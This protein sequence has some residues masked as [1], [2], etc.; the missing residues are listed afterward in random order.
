[1]KQDWNPLE[2]IMVE[3]CCV[4]SMRAHSSSPA[5][6]FLIRS[7]TD[8]LPCS[9]FA[10]R[11]S[12]SADD[13]IDD[14]PFPA[15]SFGEAA[16][17]NSLFPSLR[18]L[19]NDV[20]AL[21]NLAFLRSFQRILAEGRL[22]AEVHRVVAEKKQIVFTGHSFGGAMSVLATIWLLEQ[23]VKFDN[24]SQVIPFCLT[25][26]SPLVGD[27]VFCHSLH[28]EGWSRCF[29]HFVMPLDII[30]RIL[31]TPL[32]SC[33]EELQAILHLACPKYLYFSLDVIGNS[34][35]VAFFY[36]TI[37][38]NALLLSCHR[39][40]LAMGCANP[41]FGSLSAFVKLSPY[42]P[43]GT[44][45]FFTRKGRL[46]NFKNSDA[47]LHLLFYCLQLNPE[48]ELAEVAYGSLKEHLQYDTKVKEYLEVQYFVDVD[49]LERIPLSIND[50][51]S[52]D[53]QVFGVNFEDLDLNVEA[54]LRLRAAGELE[55]QKQ[56]NQENFDAKYCK[57]QEAL[58]CLNDYRV[59]C[60]I[61][62]LG[63]YDTFKLQQ[64]PEDFNA[65]VKRLELAGLWDEILEMLRRYD[66][67]DSFESRAEWVRLGTTYRQIVEPLDIANYYRHSK[68][69][70][71]GPY[72][73]N[74][75][76]KRYRC[77]QR[78]YEQSRRMAAGLSSE[79]CFWAM[80]EDLCTDANNNRP[81]EDVRDKVL[82]L[83]RKVLR[84][85]TNDK[86]GKDVLFHNS[87][88][89]IWWKALPE[90]HK[91]ESCIASLMSKG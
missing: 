84:W 48:Q 83:E 16:V 85:M 69:E 8:P 32:A 47:I 42:R 54:R 36:S 15:S 11:A 73:A 17:D 90:H 89:A 27:G 4:L 25:F 21:V 10:F 35:L 38:R 62:G 58:R 76:P 45:C 31:L 74:G 41:F 67:P 28:R 13:W 50:T 63:Y 57:I 68:N 86:L 14:D 81:Y 46:V 34:Q 3:R 70:D 9:V 52:N 87:T 19:G 91:S 30:P 61:R 55:K 1:M 26:G 7:F 53:R 24:N 56:K 37:L 79:S 49:Y 33:K 82:E 44:Y 71:T 29:F 22:H 5:S 2:G 51:L 39:A 43:F 78:W 18:S 77:V 72:I 65:N 59:T 12:W 6:S 75:R 88:F 20:P 80:V 60:E 40:C 23:C 66:L 64:D